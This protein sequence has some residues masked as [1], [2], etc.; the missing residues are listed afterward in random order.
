LVL[1]DSAG[2]DT[3]GHAALGAARSV[4]GYTVGRDGD[5]DCFADSFQARGVEAEDDLG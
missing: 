1:P 2:V 4:C 3:G 5:D